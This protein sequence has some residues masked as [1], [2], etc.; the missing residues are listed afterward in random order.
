LAE[1][2]EEHRSIAYHKETELKNNL[3]LINSKVTG[4]EKEYRELK[5]ECREW[6]EQ[7]NALWEKH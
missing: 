2:I 4:W 3:D 7:Y 1:E 5:Q 6:E